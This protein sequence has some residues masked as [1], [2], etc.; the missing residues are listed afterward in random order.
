MCNWSFPGY[1]YKG[2]LM[3]DSPVK[4]PWIR[5]HLMKKEIRAGFHY[6]H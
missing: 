3:V 2:T 1:N 6:L 4:E 5:I